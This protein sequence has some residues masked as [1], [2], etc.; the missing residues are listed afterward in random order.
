VAAGRV[1][2]DPLLAAANG[3]RPEPADRAVWILR[4]MSTSEDQ[5]L[6]RPALE[7]LTRLQNRPQIA[8]AARESLVALRHHEAVAA[9]EQLGGRYSESAM[10][11]GTYA[12]PRVIFDGDWRGGDAGL[13]H[14]EGLA[15]VGTVAV[16]GTEISADGLAQLQKVERLQDLV[17]IGTKLESSDVAKL[18]KLLPQVKIDY[19]RGAL[20]GVVGNSID[21]EGPPSVINV[22][23]GSAAEIAGIKV[24]DR[25]QRFENQ[26]VPSFQ[27]LTAMIGQ[28]RAGDEVTLQVLR[29]GQPIEFKLKLGAWQSFE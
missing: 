19:R 25:I 3:D 1:A 13:V 27:A 16:I 15:A 28:H 8:A 7:T 17:L 14:V 21:G 2:L 5:S 20:L 10:V 4:R 12:L 26:P 11:I 18:Q 29:D 22:Q 6:R 9:I 23:A 24:G